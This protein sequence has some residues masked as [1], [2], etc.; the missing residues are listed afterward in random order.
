MNDNSTNPD[1]S[2]KYASDEVPLPHRF[3]ARPNPPPIEG[4]LVDQTK[5]Q[6]RALV[7]EI[8]DLAKTNC[9]T[10]AFYEGF[11]LRTTS[12]L[13]SVGGA[14]WTRSNIDQ[15][16]A[17]Q[18][19]INLTQTPLAADA[20][21]QLQHS[22]LLEKLTVAAEPTL[23]PP[24][25]GT[26]DTDSG[27]PTNYL[28]MFGPLV[29]DQ[30]LVGLVEIIQRPGGGPATQR[31]YLRFLTQMCE[32][33]SD[34]LKSHRLRAFVEQQQLWQELEIFSREV[35]RSLNLKQIAFTVA[36]EGRRIIGCDRV[37]VA[38]R[39][40]GRM[41]V[42]AVSGLDTIER[43]ADQVKRLGELADSVMRTGRE[44]W[45][46]GN[47]ADLAP[48]IER[49]LH[50]YIDK[51]HAKMLA[52]I[53]LTESIVETQN[54]R[55][56]RRKRPTIIAALIVE[57]LTDTR[58]SASSKKRTEIVADHARSSLSNAFEHRSIPFAPLLG[59]LKW[60]TAP[61]EQSR[62]PKTMV[63]L[64]VIAACI[65]ALCV[66]PYPFTLGA[67]GKMIAESQQEVFA[68]V[69]GTLVN[70]FELNDPAA[71]VAEGAILAEMVNPDL[72]MQIKSLEGQLNQNQAQVLKLNRSIFERNLERRDKILIDGELAKANAAVESL[73]QEIA[74]ARQHADKLI[75]RSPIS[76]HVV[77]WQLRRNLLGRPV[78]RGESLMTVV[79]P[80]TRWQVELQVPERRVGHLLN[81]ATGNDEPISVSFSLA[82]NPGKQ[83]TGKIASIDPVLDVL[84]SEGNSNRVLVEFDNSQTPVELLRA[85]TRV[86]AKIHCG[87]RT[88]GYVLFHE[89]FETIHAT[90][91]FWF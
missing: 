70:I 12:A 56:N 31:G 16:L 8:A 22:R 39:Q 38:V 59:K 23:V 77:D 87:N 62:L 37:S 1:F 35:H 48:Q 82:S 55:N 47:D 80:D 28:L 9:T 85:G 53:P 46:Q 45:Y 79:A 4:D 52:V 42:A 91:H 67:K 27:N 3:A 83:F 61:L 20:S 13:A 64:S 54:E 68:H 65:L 75:V 34:F 88:V 24:N 58:L 29:V 21:A 71:N 44:M 84:D 74:L 10:E 15:P 11:L 19:H 17:L 25:S 69:D 26:G 51:S 5:L 14:I 60:I 6:I 63:I 18:Y 2:A 73:T 50:I 90:Y 81:A 43:R 33:A 40:A 89:L 41:C 30:Q 57:Q 72:M 7:Q 36:N 49:P 32:I 76:G 78:N 66:V 86:T